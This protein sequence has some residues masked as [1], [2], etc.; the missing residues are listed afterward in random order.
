MNVPPN[1]RLHRTRA[2][3]L[4]G[5]HRGGAASSPA[6]G[7]APVSREPLGRVISSLLLVAGIEGCGFGPHW[8]GVNVSAMD[9]WQGAAVSID[10]VEVGKL[11]YLRTHGTWFEKWLKRKGDSSMFHV[12]T[13]NV[14]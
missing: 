4:L 6:S 2:A 11:D 12:V 10:G 3:A 13:L 1:P 14:P 7:R 8:R 5:R 9:E